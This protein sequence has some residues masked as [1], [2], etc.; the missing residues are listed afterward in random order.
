MITFDDARTVVASAPSV[1]SRFGA[2]LQ[3]ADYGWENDDVYVVA[4]T[5]A[6]GEP[7]FDAPDLLVDKR[8]GELREVFGMMGSAPAP[9]LLPIGEPPE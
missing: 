7:V 2:A 1:R 4:V 3:V 8:S 5:A 9:G 6:D